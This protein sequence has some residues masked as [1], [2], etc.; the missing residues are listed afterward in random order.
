MDAL[1]LI[2]YILSIAGMVTIATVV[3]L[4]SFSKSKMFFVVAVYI[5]SVWLFVQSIVQTFSL[6]GEI[7]LRLIQFASAISFAMA[8]FFYG[9]SRLYVNKPLQKW[10]YVLVS[11][12]FVV[13]LIMNMSGYMIRDAWGEHAGII[14]NQ[15]SNLYQLYV[16][17]IGIVFMVAFYELLKSAINSKSKKDRTKDGLIVFGFLQA[18]IALVVGSIFFSESAEVQMIIPVSLLIMSIIVGLAIVRYQFFDIKSAAIRTFA[19]ILSLMTL[20]GLY[21]GLAYVLSVSL[22]RGHVSSTVSVSPVNILLA[23]ML[24]FAFQ[25]VKKF[26]DKVTNKIFYKDNYD[27]DDFYSRLNNTLTSNTDLRGLLER[28]AYEIA[29]TIKSEQAFFF[30][31]TDNGHYMSA[32]TS[33]HKQLPKY[34]ALKMAEY[35]KQDGV[36]AASQMETDDPIRRLLVSHWVELVLPLIQDGKMLGFL[37]LGD[38]KTSGYTNRDLRALNTISDGLIIAVQ[39]ALA[40]H[41]IRELNATLQQRI[42]N[43]TKELRINNATLQRLD[44]VKDEFVSIASHQLR[45][46][47]TSVKGYISMVLDGDAGEISDSQ[48]HLLEEAFL[49]SERM[50]CLINDFLNVSRL[51]TGKFVLDRYPVD[52]SKIVEQ[53]IDSLRPTAE[54]RDLKFVYHKPK[55]IP[56][57]DL[58]EGKIRQVVMNFAD[59]SI[60]YSREGTKILINLSVDGDEVLFTVKDTGIGVPKSEQAQLFT[61]FYRASNAKKQ[62]PDGTGVGLFLAKKVVDAHGGTIVFESVEGKGSTFGFRLPIKPLESSAADVN[63]LNNQNDNK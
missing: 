46:P 5:S 24:A 10:L 31:F 35:F 1:S 28:A 48:R 29:T 44:K 59:N 25:P 3:A 53:E 49:S 60:Y 63:N 39:N 15:Y 21:Y 18:V 50:V 22:F 23:L 56:I 20:S 14:I 32:G 36:V 52:L 12:F 19:Y 26:F 7:G 33:R 17:A 8:F 37:C 51:Q 9:F 30:I 2:I 58:D 4:S 41:E 6:H 62:R 61:K 34:D 11:I 27:T 43:A 45:T 54:A 47:L 42:N 38:H 57:L 13:E 16:L 55:D 40:V